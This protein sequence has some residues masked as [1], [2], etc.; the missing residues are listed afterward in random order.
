V[1]GHE[2]ALA[3]LY[4][5]KLQAC[6]SDARRRMGTWERGCSGAGRGMP[7]WARR[8]ITRERRMSG[9]KRPPTWQCK[10]DRRASFEV[11]DGG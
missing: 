9:N 7:E 4:D 8:K 10:D 1:K 5:G 6:C 11:G 2:A 3:A